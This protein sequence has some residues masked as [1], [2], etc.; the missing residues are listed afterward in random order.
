VTARGPRAIRAVS[1]ALVAVLCGLLGASA[2]A[3][4]EG[5]RRFSNWGISFVYPTSWYVTTE[6][7]SNGIEPA[8]R[9]AAGNFRFHRTARD[10]GP[11]LEGIAKQRTDLG[12]LAFMREALGADA[13]R[14]RAPPRPKRFRLPRATDQAACLG[15]G[16]SQVVF[17]EAGRILY[18][19]ISIAPKA[20]PVARAQLSA[21]L[22]SIRIARA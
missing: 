1:L 20:S 4:S 17:R 7:L 13:R 12:V 19:W 2:Q 16:S 5:T 14:T 22:A 10:L 21:L 3:T 18:L 8:Y 9:F 15:P 11:C 6:P